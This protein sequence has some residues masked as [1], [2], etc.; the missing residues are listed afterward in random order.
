[1]G[2][3]MGYTGRIGNVVHYKMGNKF[4]SRSVPKKYKQT[5]ATK[6]KAS[7]FGMASTIGKVIRENMGAVIFNNGD[8]KMQTRLVGEIFRWLQLARNEPASSV[9]QPLLERFIFSTGSPTLSARWKAKFEVGSPASGQ[10]Q[11]AIP[12]FIPETDFKA[13]ARTAIVVCSI[14]SVVIDLVNKKEIGSAQNEISFTMDKNKVDAQNIIQEL[15]MPKG[16]LL[17]TGMSLTFSIVRR[18]LTVPTKD[19]LYQPAQIIYSVYH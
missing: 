3:Q 5:K 16:S 10:I 9:T 13:P 4:Y 8:R 6:A 15:P 2:T 11:I 19:K 14:V 12:A 7:E 17:V 1:M 18:Q